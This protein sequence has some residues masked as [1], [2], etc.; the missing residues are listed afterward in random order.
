MILRILLWILCFIP[1]SLTAQLRD[2]S[3][4]GSLRDSST[5]MAVGSASIMLKKYDEPFSRSSISDKTGFFSMDS[6]KE[7]KYRLVISFSGYSSF[8][9]DSILIKADRKDINLGEIILVPSAL[10][11]ETIV[12]YAEKPLI[13]SKEGNITMNVA[14]SPMSAGSNAADLLK[15]MPLVNADPDGK[16]TVRGREPRIL[17]DEK[18]VDLNGMQLSDFLESLPGGMIEKIEVMTNP[19]AQFAQEPGGVINIVTRKGK[20]GLTGRA[21]VFGGSRGE[22]G[23]NVNL[24]YRQKGLALSLTAGD[25]YNSFAG[26]GSSVRENYYADSSN[27]LKT[28]NEYVNISRRPNMRFSMD[29]DFNAR[30]SVNLVLTYNGNNFDNDGTTQ[31]ANFNDAGLNYRNSTRKILSSGNNRNPGANLSYTHKGR[32]PGEQLRIQLG[33]NKSWQ[34]NARYFRQAFFDSKGNPF[35]EDSLQSQFV[36]NQTMGLNIRGG[37]DFPVNKGKTVFSAGGAYFLQQS[38]VL[39]NTFYEDQNGDEVFVDI[40]SNDLGFAQGVSNLRAS[41]KQK[42]NKWISLNTGIT[43][44]STDI[45]FDLYKTGDKVSNHYANWLPFGG[46]YFN[47]E[48]GRNASLVYRRT[49]RRPGIRELNPSIDYTDPYNLRSG[50]PFLEPTFADNVDLTVGKTTSKFYANLGLGFNL[51][52]N[53]FASLRTLIDEG[54]TMTTW[55]NIDTKKEYE[56]SAWA[57][58]TITKGLRVNGSA[59]Y[60]YNQYSTADIQQ[61]KYRN[62]GSVNAKLNLSYALKDIWIF[63]G[64]VNYNRFANPQGTVRSTVAM[65]FG[66]QKKFYKKK[67]L[68]TLNM[69]DPVIQQTYQNTTTGTNFMVYSEGTTETRNFRLTLAYNFKLKT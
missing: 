14:E 16:V 32:K 67:L 44:E 56:I 11:L 6:L 31:Y 8:V 19:P 42:F 65:N 68:V 29:Y 22:A 1:F 54:K 62:G 26:F 28:S 66:V 55:Y 48:N 38:N 59:G 46:L 7:G 27:Q 35:G 9:M 57:G 39:Q 50:N 20:G 3:L 45:R 17:V 64:N 4:E 61:Y 13:Q 33:W 25:T 41:V 51:V 49:I 34:D 15:N 43:W 53:I 37:Y 21:T 18:P 47:A 12:I 58:Y 52:N 69:I 24:N 5:R 60:V 40:L 63:T 36:D 10:N 23:V 30:N 2:G